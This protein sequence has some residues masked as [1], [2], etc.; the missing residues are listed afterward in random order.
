MLKR[1]LQLAACLALMSGHASAA[2]PD[3]NLRGDRFKPLTYDAL[4]A[5]Q[6]K[7]ADN[8]LAGSRGRL[9]GPYNILLRSPVMGDLAQKLGEQVRFRSSLPKKLNELAILLVGADWKSEY[10]WYAHSGYAKEAGL[11]PAI[12]ESI[13]KHE[14]PARLDDGE[15]AVYDFGTELL[16]TRQVSDAS[17]KR[18]VDRFGEKGAADL[19]G[20]MGYYVMVCMLLNVDR[21]PLPEGAQPQLG[22]PTKVATAGR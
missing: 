2:S 5:E 14:R 3:L 4:D 6:K 11:D 20:V 10:E 16:R 9:N 13:K 17:F 1:S 12:I 21:Y 7:M 18:V 19:M 22:G 15:A 8:I